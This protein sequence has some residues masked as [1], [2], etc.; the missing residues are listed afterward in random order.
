MKA[1]CNSPGCIAAAVASVP[2]ISLAAAL[3]DSLNGMISVEHRSWSFKVEFSRPGAADFGGGLKLSGVHWISPYK[4]ALQPIKN[5]IAVVDSISLP[6]AFAIYYDEYNPPFATVGALFRDGVQWK[7][8]KFI[9]ADFDYGSPFIPLRWSAGPSVDFDAAK[10]LAALQESSTL[11]AFEVIHVDKKDQQAKPAGG[12]YANKKMELKPDGELEIE[13]MARFQLLNYQFV[14][15]YR[16]LDDGRIEFGVLLGG[17]LFNGQGVL[18]LHDFVFRINPSNQFGNLPRWDYLRRQQHAVALHLA[19]PVGVRKVVAPLQDF[20]WVP[21]TT[22]GPQTAPD[23]DVVAVRFRSAAYN[24][25][26]SPVHVSQE[27]KFNPS[28]ERSIEV[29]GGHSA[30]PD[31][32]VT[33]AD[34]YLSGKLPAKDLVV[35]A[36]NP[37]ASGPYPVFALDPLAASKS[38]AG[39]PLALGSKVEAFVVLRHFHMPRSEQAVKMP[40]EYHFLTLTPRDFADGQ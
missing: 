12:K 5:P 13:I 33:S 24:P 1:P 11:S 34:Y 22:A 9:E 38:L 39:A 30:E 35:D 32:I 18:H 14:S 29:S 31:Q 19:T 40:Y 16:F 37:K 2:T 17:A 8:S 27:Y 3:L 7:T 4:N 36:Q 25:G 6:L 15:V 21:C 26:D 20:H 28:F 23:G 10:A